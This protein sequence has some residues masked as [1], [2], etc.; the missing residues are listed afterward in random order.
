MDGC[1]IDL[2][3]GELEQYI[4]IG[5]DINIGYGHGH[6][7]NLDGVLAPMSFDC[8]KWEAC[9]KCLN[10]LLV[11]ISPMPRAILVSAC[12]SHDVVRLKQPPRVRVSSPSF[13]EYYD[14]IALE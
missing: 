5:Y 3:R 8:C 11:L 9:R 2:D 13:C 7:A 6:V 12:R 14:S 1:S 10:N 4:N